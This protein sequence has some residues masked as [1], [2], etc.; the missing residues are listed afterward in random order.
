M[1]LEPTQVKR[2]LKMEMELGPGLTQVT[3]AG[4][5]LK[6]EMKPGSCPS[7]VRAGSGKELDR[8]TEMGPGPGPSQV[9]R[10]GLGKERALKTEM[11][12]D[13]GSRNQARK[14]ELEQG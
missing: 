14:K 4:S 11:E 10:E 3:R 5:A 1:G 12:Q 6:T 2:A 8:K 7:Q 9:R 13:P